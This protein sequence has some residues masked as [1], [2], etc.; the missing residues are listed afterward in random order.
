MPSFLQ[1]SAISYRDVAETL[2]MGG[3][4]ITEG[5]ATY[6]TLTNGDYTVRVNGRDIAFDESGTMT[7]GTLEGYRLYAG[8]S[9]GGQQLLICDTNF[10]LADPDLFNAAFGLAR[11]GALRDAVTLVMQDWE[12]EYYSHTNYSGGYLRGLSGGDGLF[13]AGLSDF[14]FGNGGEDTVVL[15]GGHD[16]GYGGA[17]RDWIY[18]GPGD[19]RMYGGAGD[20]N[21]TSD[22]WR[23]SEAG[24][25][26]AYGGIG[27]DGIAGGFGRDTLYGGAGDDFLNG[28]RDSDSLNGGAG[29]DSIRGGAGFDT[30]TGGE[31]DDSLDG[32]ADD[33]RLSGGHGH[34]LLVGAVG[35]DVLV[36]GDGDDI[37]R[38]DA[39]A[40]RLFGGADDDTLNGGLGSDELTGGSGADRFVISGADTQ[41]FTDSILD[42]ELSVDTIVFSGFGLSTV[43]E[44]IG[45]AIDTAD[46]VLFMLSPARWVVVAGVEVL[47]FAGTDDLIVI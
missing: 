21:I 23:P 26:L 3:T 8:D 31:G 32:G 20:D 14:I 40:D 46:G 19:D 27:N 43:D 33:D 29:N 18:G 45:L 9:V 41:P 42:F 36:A 13:G 24:H 5:D 17:D 6:F 44:L 37:L 25:D 38:G 11:S 16:E 2:F 7:S 12:Q 35:N 28:E 4:T 22:E 1:L 30:L 34:D 39:G 47:Q 15:G 10:G